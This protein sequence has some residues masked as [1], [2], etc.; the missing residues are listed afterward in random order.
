MHYARVRCT[1]WLRWASWV[2]VSCIMVTISPSRVICTPWSV[3]V[4]VAAG[5]SWSS[6]GGVMSARGLRGAATLRRRWLFS[7]FTRNRQSGQ[8]C[9]PWY[10]SAQALAGLRRR[11]RVMSSSSSGCGSAQS[12]VCTRRR[13]RWFWRGSNCCLS[14]GGGC[15]SSHH[16]RPSNGVRHGRHGGAVLQRTMV[17][18]S[19]LPSP[20]CSTGNVGWDGLLFLSIFGFAVAVFGFAVTVF[21]FALIFFTSGVVSL[22]Y[23]A[24]L[25]WYSA[26]QWRY[27]A[28]P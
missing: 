23:S 6:S 19:C 5:A 7:I 4:G 10:Q 1:T 25:S 17:S 27:S 18:G 28:L 14:S 20:C 15:G 3:A 2:V 16:S 12:R 21:G 11:S 26:L 9:F 8:T 13:R 22:R 24:S